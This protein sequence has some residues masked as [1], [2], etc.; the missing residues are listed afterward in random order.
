MGDGMEATAPVPPAATA[1]AGERTR[2]LVLAATIL[3]SALG[4]VDVTVVNIAMP[5]IQ[6][7]LG[8]SFRAIQ[9]VASA[10]M[11][12]LTALILVAGGLGDRFGRRRLFVIGLVVFAAASLGCALAPDAAMLIAARAVQGLGAALLIP[13]SLAII[14]ATFPREV[15]GRAIGTWAAASSIT[16]ALGPPLGGFLVDTL[17]WRSAFWLN[18]PLAAV[19]LWLTLAA[20]PESR[21]E[22][23]GGRLDFAGALVAALAFGALAYGLT[24]FSDAG[25]S[26]AA[27]LGWVGG[28]LAGLAVF[29]AIEARAQNPILPLALFRS[30]VFAG[31]NLMTVFL[32]GALAGMMFLLPFDLVARRGLTA[33]EAGVTIL[34]VGIIIGLFARRTGALADRT[35]PR[36]FLIGGSLLVAAGCALLALGPA[37]YF[38][39][40]LLPVLL[41]AAGMALVVSPLTTAVM[42]A[43]P[44]SKAGAASGISNAASRVA[45]LLAVALFGAFASALYRSAAGPAADRFGVL[46]P[47][48]D[49]AR[50]ALEA[51]FASGYGG[52]MWLAALWAALAALS[53]VALIGSGTPKAG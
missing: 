52:A 34:P 41:V 33:A 10:Y 29:V 7:S 42:N 15:R 16:T 31:A 17:G 9:W 5:A 22:T 28:G 51:A 19:A 21:D 36:P 53:V 49:P 18:L 1:V 26:A 25:A 27:A 20:V 45:G 40:A 50:P 46:P 2:R 12:V 11:L 14:T 39:G 44:E 24:L 37:S 6:A 47:A 43:A 8:A 3:A 32:Y 4:F 13:Q 30:P 23:A 38:A 48:A 35:G